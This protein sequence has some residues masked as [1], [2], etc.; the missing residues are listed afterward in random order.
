[1]LQQTADRAMCTRMAHGAISAFSGRDPAL[2]STRIELDGRLHVA[3]SDFLRFPQAYFRLSGI[4]GIGTQ[5]L[6]R[7]RE[8]R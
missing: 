2:F 7:L 1:M 6:R 3:V 5:R 4:R 8:L